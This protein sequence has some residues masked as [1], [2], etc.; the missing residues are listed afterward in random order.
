MCPLKK[1]KFTIFF[2]HV[3]L[4]KDPKQD[5]DSKLLTLRIRIRKFYWFWVCRAS[6]EGKDPVV[7]AIT[8]P[9]GD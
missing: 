5:P 3:I 8:L 9:S 7:T 2:H 4:G 1:M 6:V